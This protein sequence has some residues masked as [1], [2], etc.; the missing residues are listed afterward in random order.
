[1]RD[2]PRQRENL[3]WDIFCYADK[4]KLDVKNEAASFY[5]VGRNTG[6]CYTL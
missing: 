1:M 2:A 6:A 5:T 3:L 4:Y